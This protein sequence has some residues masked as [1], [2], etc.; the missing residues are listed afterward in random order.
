MGIETVLKGRIS[1]IIAHR[2]STIRAASRIVV[3]D[4]GQIVEQGTHMELLGRRGAYSRLYAQQFR[5]EAA[6]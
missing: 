1:V 5:R 6:S 4:K 3:M 2:L